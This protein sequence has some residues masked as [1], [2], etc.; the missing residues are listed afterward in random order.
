[1]AEERIRVVLADDNRAVLHAIADFLLGF[2]D[3]EILG[4]AADGN[5]VVEL[6]RQL[7][8]DVVVMDISMPGMNG[9][10]AIRVIRTE[11]PEIQV[12]VLS[13]FDETLVGHSA[14]RFGAAIYLS[15]LQPLEAL[16]AA[17]RNCKS[18]PPF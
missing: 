8:P 12:V 1:M 18:S 9:I 6:A 13:M 4:E 10:E 11:H 17:I 2:S 14:Q 7:R 3:I 15:K 5:A 16:L